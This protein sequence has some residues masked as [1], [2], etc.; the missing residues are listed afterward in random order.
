[1]KKLIIS[2]NL[3]ITFPYLQSRKLAQKYLD[4]DILNLN[5]KMDPNITLMISEKKL[6]QNQLVQLKPII[7]LYGFQTKIAKK[8]LNLIRLIG[9]YK[10]VINLQKNMTL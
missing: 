7:E 1:M 5:I 3:I 10:L 6:K 4:K 2:K 8:D 9:L